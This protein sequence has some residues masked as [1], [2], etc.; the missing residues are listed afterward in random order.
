MA[1]IGVFIPGVAEHETLVSSKDDQLGTLASQLRQLGHE[2]VPISSD[3]ATHFLSF[4][5]HHKNFKLYSKRIPLRNRILVVQEPLVVQPSNYSKRVRRGYGH[6][7]ALTP[8]AG[9]TSTPWPQLNWPKMATLCENYSEPGT[10]VMINTNINSFLP[11]SRYGLRRSVANAFARGGVKIN[12]AGAGWQL[13]DW[14][15][16]KQNLVGIAYAAINGFVPR[17]LQWNSGVVS[18]KNLNL[19]G[20]VKDKQQYLLGFDF[21][22]VIENSS[23]YISEKLFDAIFAGCIPLYHG[24]KLS[25][26]DIPEGIAIELPNQPQAFVE[27]YANTN[28][29]KKRAM[30]SAA[31][32]WLS[33]P[34]TIQKWAGPGAT[35]CLVDEIVLCLK[36]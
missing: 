4:D 6:V 23:D 12:L 28:S 30:R 15:L 20:K 14:Q 36:P 21:A 9:V 17:I 8:A 26:F 35:K 2:V 19:A 5:H 13:K 24:P 25:A 16:L 31:R 29:A 33:K 1:V 22:V 7:L 34:E 10:L 27:A 32:A 11:G 18:S 3:S